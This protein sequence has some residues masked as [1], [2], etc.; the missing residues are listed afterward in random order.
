V[1]TADGQPFDLYG[2]RLAIAGGTVL[3]GSEFHPN[4]AGVQVG[5]SYVYSRVNGQWVQLYQL[6]PI[7][8]M[9]FGE[10]GCSLATDGRTLV[11]GAGKQGVSAGPFSGEAYTYEF[12]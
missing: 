10:F 8:G 1:H 3:I 5:A 12:D 11:V 9:E 7:D 4:A 6:Q 2:E